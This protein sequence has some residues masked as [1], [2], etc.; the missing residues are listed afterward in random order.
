MHSTSIALKLGENTEEHMPPLFQGSVAAV[1]TQVDI[2]KI[3]HRWATSKP[4]TFFGLRAYFTTH[5]AMGPEMG[6]K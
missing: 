1:L 2:L 4:P 6:Q 5:H 3:L